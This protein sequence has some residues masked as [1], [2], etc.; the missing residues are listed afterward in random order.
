MTTDDRDQKPPETLA[1]RQSRPIDRR[2]QSG[3]TLI[4]LLVVIV[5]LGM[6]IG[7]VVPAV[8]RAVGTAKDAAVSSEIQGIGQALAAFKNQFGDYP[9]SRIV[10]SENGKYDVATLG[11][12]GSPFA[13][14][15]PRTLAA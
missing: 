8:M 15:A 13:K 6:L 10:C 11:G 12:A 14:L 2:Q 3:F 4:E 1:M 9:P 5:I 7:L